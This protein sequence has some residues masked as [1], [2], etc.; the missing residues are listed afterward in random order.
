MLFPGATAGV[1]RDADRARRS[2]AGVAGM[3]LFDGDG[4]VFS[5]VA[6][7][8]GGSVFDGWRRTTFSSGGGCG[9]DLD[10]GVRVCSY[11]DGAE[12]TKRRPGEVLGTGFAVF[13][14]V[15]GLLGS[16]DFVVA[17][18]SVL[19]RGLKTRG[20][21]SVSTVRLI[22]S[23][24]M[25]ESNSNSGSFGGR[26]GALRGFLLLGVPAVILDMM[27]FILGAD[28]GLFSYCVGGSESSASGFWVVVC[29]FSS[30]FG[31]S[32]FLG[33]F[34]FSVLIFRA[35]CSARRS[36]SGITSF[37]AI[38]SSGDSFV[39]VSCCVVSADFFG[40]FC[41]IS[42]FGGLFLMF[43]AI[44]LNGSA[45]SSSRDFSVLSMNLSRVEIFVLVTSSAETKKTPMDTPI[46]QG[47]YCCG[48]VNRASLNNEVPRNPPG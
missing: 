19:F 47:S 14:L 16:G 42:I 6:M 24:G 7:I 10:S 27:A 43:L 32:I 8:V 17:G 36:D 26:V 11:F 13:V 12:G 45:A 22:F 18:M 5:G 2:G 41:V 44:F 34:S 4:G 46:I 23:G 25:S 48:S 29:C 33:I 39:L 9:A 35:F 30:D 1:F 21:H 15:M 28:W 31:V 38:I 40:I 37:C 20:V 3:V